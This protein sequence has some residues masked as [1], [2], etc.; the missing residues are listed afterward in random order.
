MPRLIQACAQ[1]ND[2]N[3]PLLCQWNR[4]RKRMHYNTLTSAIGRAK[5]A[6]GITKQWGL[7]DLR[8][9]GARNL[10]ERTK[11]VR[12][13]QRFLGHSSLNQSFWY[14][15]NAGVD[16]SS[17]DLEPIELGKEKIA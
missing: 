8:R 10:Y 14:L 3:E 4:G 2:D 6:V 1:A 17:D 15:G 16:L 9:T 12:K 11:D 5:K 13:V 7:H